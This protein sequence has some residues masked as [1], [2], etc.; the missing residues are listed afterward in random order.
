MTKA[1]TKKKTTKNPKSRSHRD[2]SKIEKKLDLSETINRFEFH[3]HASALL[4][5]PEDERP[6]VAVLI[7]KDLNDPGERFCSCSLSKRKTC[8]H[9]LQIMQVYKTLTESLKGNS[10]NEDFRSS[11]WYRIASILADGNMA[12]LKEIRIRTVPNDEGSITI[13]TDS[14]KREL[15]RYLSN[16]PDQSRFI[17]RCLEI[18]SDDGDV[19]PQRSMVINKLV[20]YSL[21][22][23]E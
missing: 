8:P 5:G 18:P 15:L 23:N 11:I 14:M 17:E 22:Q 6:G 1:K 20:S 21:N 2:K 10:P 9:I 16:G 3:R 19:V 12:T 7:K 4:P 13:V